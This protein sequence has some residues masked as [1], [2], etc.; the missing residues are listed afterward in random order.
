MIAEVRGGEGVKLE[1]PVV[2]TEGGIVPLS[3]TPFADALAPVRRAH[4]PS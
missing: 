1:Q 3:G 2:I 4:W